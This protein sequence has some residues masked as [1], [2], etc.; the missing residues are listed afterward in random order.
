MIEVSM[1]VLIS[2]KKEVATVTTSEVTV[3]G[4]TWVECEGTVTDEGTDAVITRGFCWSTEHAPTISD[5]KTTEKAGAGIFTHNINSFIVNSTYY[6]RA[7]ATNSVGTGYGNE[8]SFIV[9]E[10]IPGPVVTD[11]DGNSYNSVQNGTQIWMQE[12]LKTTKYKD[13][14]LIPLV[15]DNTSWVGLT[16][17]AYCWLKNDAPT[18]KDTYGALYN[19]YTISSKLCP[20]GWHI[21]TWDEWFSLLI[22]TAGATESGRLKEAGTAH[23]LSPN[24]SA[25]N[26]SGF[27]ALPG[28]LRVEDG[29]FPG[30][31]GTD[32]WWWT[33][34]ED[35]N[36]IEIWGETVSYSGG[37]LGKVCGL[38]VRCIKD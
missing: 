20:A 27:T 22:F 8:Q 28:S 19:G 17:P 14:T 10:N 5:S 11:L 34:T 30:S 4:V 1:I 35:N 15:T 31:V 32:G 13:G 26:E 25:T 33:A 29:S 16:S 18:Y 23:W 6:V 21:P 7:Y 9:V 3:H 12:N 37:R 36:V 38:S 2:C 24:T